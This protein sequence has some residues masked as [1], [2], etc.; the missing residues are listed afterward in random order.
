M[1]W[2][3][4]ETNN[5][6][7]DIA[8]TRAVHAPPYNHETTKARIWMQD[9]HLHILPAGGGRLVIKLCEV[10]FKHYFGDEAPYPD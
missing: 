6:I 4:E 7:E 10:D 1:I 8:K 2:K 5:I 3:D 9:D